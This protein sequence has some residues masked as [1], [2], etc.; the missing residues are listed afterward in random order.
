MS[1]IGFVIGFRKKNIYVK[2][3]AKKEFLNYCFIDPL[4]NSELDTLSISK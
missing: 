4:I 3:V 2:H 1:N